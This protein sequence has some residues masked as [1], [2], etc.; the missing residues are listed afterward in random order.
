VPVKID[1]VTAD[2]PS[3]DFLLTFEAQDGLGKLWSHQEKVNFC[4][5]DP[6]DVVSGKLSTFSGR[7]MTDVIVYRQLVICVFMALVGLFLSRRVTWMPICYLF[8]RCVAMI[9]RPFI[10]S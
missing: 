7:I 9:Q 5:H 2:L 8:G 6:G 4:P 3:E 10:S 1:S